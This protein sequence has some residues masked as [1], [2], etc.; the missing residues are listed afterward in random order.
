MVDLYICDDNENIRK[1][2]ERI[3]QKQITIR[4]YD[5]RIVLS[6]K[7]PEEVLKRAK[8]NK[9]SGVY[10]LDVE[11]KGEQMDGFELGKEIRS[12][13]ANGT[14]IYITA[15]KELAFRTFQ[16]H[17]EA[18]DYIVKEDGSKLE[19]AIGECL[20]EIV[21]RLKNTSQ[22]EE[23]EYYTLKL[24]DVLRHIPVD[25]IYYFETSQK[26]HRVGLCAKEEYLE[27]PGNLKEIEKELGDRFIRIHRSF[28]VNKE[29]IS[30]LDR[31]SGQ[32]IMENGDRPFVAR[33][34]RGKLE[35]AMKERGK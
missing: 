16:Y 3:I 27:F 6:T 35:Q 17:I 13:D 24:F 8:E 2:I 25:E 34:M 9:H 4:E 29:K 15:F 22:K 21:K 33:S 12:F 30:G 28:I 10:F 26:A 32:V 19:G 11:L 7:K 20:S 18:L 1:E 23:R 5:M 31:K 14:V